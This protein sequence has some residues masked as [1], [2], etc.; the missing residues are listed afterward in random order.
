[1]RK[2][3]TVCSETCGCGKDKIVTHSEPHNFCD[4]PEH[5]SDD[6]DVSDRMGRCGGH[7]CIVGHHFDCGGRVLMVT[8]E[9]GET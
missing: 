8:T 4:E 1:M 2:D 3:H 5:A 6:R 9:P 7:V